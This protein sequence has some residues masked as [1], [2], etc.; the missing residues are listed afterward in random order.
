M[1]KLDAYNPRI[2]DPMNHS[3]SAPR[4]SM[5]MSVLGMLF[6]MTF[7][8]ETMAD[9]FDFPPE[10]VPPEIVEPY[11]VPPDSD[12]DVKLFWPSSEPS[13]SP[14]SE[15]IPPAGLQNA[16]PPTAKPQPQPKP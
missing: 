10:I 11:K 14:F 12:V 16:K 4:W 3:A 1:G 9:E 13:S 15:P 5:L 6:C 7:A 2:P 8:G